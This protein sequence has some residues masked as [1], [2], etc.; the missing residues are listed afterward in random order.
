MR[1]NPVI[2]EVVKGYLENYSKYPSQT[3]AKIIY[4]QN[5]ELGTLASIR[6]AV[7]YYRGNM[8]KRHLERLS[9]TKFV[10]NAEE[11]MK[12][13]DI[14]A[15]IPESDKE[16]YTPYALANGKWLVMSDGHIPYHEPDVIRIAINYAVK[17]KVTGVAFLGDWIDCFALSRF[18]KDPRKRSFKGELDATNGLLNYVEK[19]IKGKIVFKLGNHE[20]RLEKYLYT[21][22]PALL[23]VVDYQYND[24]LYLIDRGAD[25]VKAEQ[26]IDAGHL[27]MLH[28]HEYAGG[29]SSPVN[30][31][32]SMFL[33]AKSCTL[34]GH[35]HRTSQNT[36]PTIRDASI[37]NWSL[38]CMC[39]LHPQYMPLNKWCHGFAIVEKHG[40]D[41]EIDNKRVLKG[42]VL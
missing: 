28:G 24:L 14:P 30:P 31:A 32:R 20:N 16:E 15:E 3:L 7:M 29:S 1:G 19:K 9:D 10:S 11:R 41:F 8:G 13:R 4:K 18:C 36:E 35:E 21:Q 26:I 27:T 6:A 40:M 37:S 17:V 2:G 12:F 38:G 22:A 39:E 23:D 25:Y 34:A 5:P 33:K 42:E